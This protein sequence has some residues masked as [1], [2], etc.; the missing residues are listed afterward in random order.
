MP[1]KAGIQNMTYRVWIPVYT[2]MTA[3]KLHPSILSFLRV[4]AALREINF[5]F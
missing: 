4:F 1:A 2:G 5:L 3:G